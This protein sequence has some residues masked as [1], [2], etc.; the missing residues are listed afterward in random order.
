MDKLFKPLPILLTLLK[1][2]QH[3]YNYNVPLEQGY[4]NKICFPSLG[5]DCHE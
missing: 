4:L 2:N 3:I 1:Y 5:K